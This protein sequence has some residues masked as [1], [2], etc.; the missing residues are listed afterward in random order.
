MNSQTT[1]LTDSKTASCLET[2]RRLIKII[3]GIINNKKAELS[4]GTDFERVMRL[5]YAHRISGM[6]AYCVKNYDLPE[7]IKSKLEAELFKTAARHTAQEREVQ[8]LSKCFSEEKIEHCFLKG[9]KISSLYDVPEMRFMLDIDIYVKPEKFD[10][11]IK[12]TEKRGYEKISVDEKDCSL[13]KKPF[14]NIDLHRELKYDFDLGYDF[15][16]KVYERLVPVENSYEKVMTKEELYV[17][18]LS[19]TAHHFATAGTGIKSVIDHYY[20]MKNLVPQ[21]DENA[22]KGYLKESG[23]EEFNEK[24]SRLARVWFMGAES[25]AVTDQMA[26]YIILSGAYGT[27]INYYV[28]GVLRM[29]MSENKKTYFVKRLFP[30][31]ETMCFRYPILKKC[32][33][34]LPVFWCL[35]ILS[36]LTQTDRI[37]NEASGIS[38]VDEENKNKQEEF[39]K[40]VGL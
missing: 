32:K 27:D 11:A 30:N 2:G 18:L 19:H 39:L 33:L 17:Y 16:K 28:N 4:E 15:Y 25:D 21:C 37:K 36:S 6:A 5:A 12:V 20:I 31:Y 40:N 9:L 29:G 7:A 22:L 23:L 35:R 34:L 38:S 14:L 26:D 3:D 1:E 13:S 24:F 10:E 8:E